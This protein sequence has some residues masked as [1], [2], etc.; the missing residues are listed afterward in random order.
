VNDDRFATRA[1]LMFFC[2]FCLLMVTLVGTCRMNSE[3]DKAVAAQYAGALK[4]VG[5]CIGVPPEYGPKL[6]TLQ[7][8]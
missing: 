7:R 5:A 2:G 1:L 8:R 4:Y 3:R 6:E